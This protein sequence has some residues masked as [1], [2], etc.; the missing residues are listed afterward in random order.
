MFKKDN[1]LVK[2]HMTEVTP[3]KVKCLIHGNTH[4]IIKIMIDQLTDIMADSVIEETSAEEVAAEAAE[5]IRNILKA[6]ILKKRE[7]AQNG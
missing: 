6:K 4:R 2:I 7:G 1:G 3:G 5:L